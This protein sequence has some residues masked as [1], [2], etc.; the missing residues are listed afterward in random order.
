MHK[1]RVFLLPVF[2]LLSILIGCQ[3][4]T[5][6]KLDF[7]LSE[8]TITTAWVQSGL[9]EFTSLSE[10]EHTERRSIYTL[11]AENS[12]GK[13]TFNIR[14]TLVDEA[15]YLQ[16]LCSLPN[17]NQGSDFAWSYWKGPIV[18]SSI[19]YGGFVDSEAL[20]S[21]LSKQELVDS[22]TS[23]LPTCDLDFTDCY[24]QVVYIKSS[25]QQ[26][27]AF[28]SIILCD[29]KQALDSLRHSD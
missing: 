10:D 17:T 7:P 5:M 19:L 21:E 28:L 2:F 6:P 8:S 25:I 12:S 18:F 29:S 14:S 15:R 20:Y 22:E 23:G 24:C 9:P 11:L 26:D 1:K 27:S 4:K 16:V 3:T 13:M